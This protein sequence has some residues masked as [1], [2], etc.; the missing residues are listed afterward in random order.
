MAW[1]GLVGC[2]GRGGGGDG[3]AAA[4]GSVGDGRA[5]GRWWGEGTSIDGP[6]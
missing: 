2:G 5:A 6:T 4:G 1:R 3:A